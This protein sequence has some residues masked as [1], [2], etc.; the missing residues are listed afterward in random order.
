MNNSICA[1]TTKNLNDVYEIQGDQ[2]TASFNVSL[3][4]IDAHE[5]VDPNILT[6]L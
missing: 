3:I 1:L 6:L 2:T 5:I 4:N